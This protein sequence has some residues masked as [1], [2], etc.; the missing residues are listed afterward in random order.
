M[1]R[2]RLLLF[3]II[4]TTTIAASCEKE[5]HIT[6]TTSLNGLWA[7]SGNN[8]EADVQTLILAEFSDGRAML[9]TYN[10]GKG[11]SSISADKEYAA[12]VTYKSSKG[13]G[14]IKVDGEA[15]MSFEFGLS[16][17]SDMMF[18]RN[19]SR[20]VSLARYDVSLDE[21]VRSLQS[22]LTPNIQMMEGFTGPS[23]YVRLNALKPSLSVAFNADPVKET[24][25]QWIAKGLVSGASSTVARLIIQSLVQD[26]ESKTLDTILSQVNMVNAQLAELI[27]LV[28]NTTY[29]K[30]LNERTSSY[31]NPMRNLSNEYI[32]RVKEAW[33]D[34]PDSVGPIVIEW[35]NRT[36]GGN[37]AYVEVKNFIDYLTGTVVEQKNLYQM[38][39]MYV[40]NTHPWE[41]MGYEVRENLRAGDLAVIAQSLFLTRL[42]YAYGNFTETT[43]ESLC[44]E[45]RGCFENYQTFCKAHPVEHHDDQAI[46]QIKG[47][48]FS[49]PKEL[50]SRDFY[51]HPWMPY[52][53]PWEFEN[54]ESAWWLVNG[55]THYNCAQIFKFCMSEDEAKAIS[56][57]Y[58]ASPYKSMVEVLTKDAECTLP[59]NENQMSGKKI[60]MQLQTDASDP[61]QEYNN[62]YI[63]ANKAMEA[64]KDFSVGEKSI[65]IAWL[66][67]H[68]FLW[69]EQWF[70][71][72][73]TYYD[74]QLWFRT[75]I[76]ARF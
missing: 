13:R 25:W 20:R 71:Q 54:Q 28:H 61:H 43:R 18:L 6:Y 68:G 24:I 49:M 9:H 11:L 27:N 14:E 58:K 47:S 2:N 10:I 62:Y 45:L 33:Q 38:Y 34:D 42:Y 73:D 12:S 37:P 15:S 8:L 55:D 64:S 59:F 52:E 21:M 74:D 66:E 50:V 75:Q 32:L 39:D 29:E 1:R 67:R 41:N 5:E 26:E 16:K 72:W 60:M 3:T 48:H 56:G 53:T 69:M 46:C 31:L 57:Y 51:N 35:A 30:Y 22:S 65:G 7:S 40:Y 44:E 76:T 63:K 23:E 4:L 19:D 70:K 17:S 36:V